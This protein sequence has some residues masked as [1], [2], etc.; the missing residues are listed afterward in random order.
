MPANC[1]PQATTATF[2]E[3]DRS[4]DDPAG[5]DPTPTL[6]TPLLSVPRSRDPIRA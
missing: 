6:T 2:L 5:S 4:H 3:P 1:T